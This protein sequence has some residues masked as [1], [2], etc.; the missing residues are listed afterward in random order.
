M[1]EKNTQY[2]SDIIAL[3]KESSAHSPVPS[4]ISSPISPS[5]SLQNRQQSP[6]Q[7]SA[8]SSSSTSSSSASS[9]SSKPA[10][11]SPM[12]VSSKKTAKR[13]RGNLPKVVTGILRDWLSKHKKHPYPT[14]EEKV[15]LAKE[16]NLT[17]NQIS[18]WF[19]N[20]RRRIL[21]PMLDQEIEMNSKD[22]SI[23]SFESSRSDQEISK[24]LFADE[25]E[26]SN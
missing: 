14:E 17:L 9:T 7:R 13:R 4:L 11:S 8:S 18:N 15:A 24:S 21:Q 20:A 25:K 5:S 2:W 3:S 16:T 23:L 12:L 22:L 10:P 19:I 1:L 6:R 26:N